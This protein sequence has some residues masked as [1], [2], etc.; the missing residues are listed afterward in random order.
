MSA[1]PDAISPDR[2]PIKTRSAWWVQAVTGGLI[3][4]GVSPNQVSLASIGFAAIGAALLVCEARGVVSA[5]ALIITAVCIQLRLLANVVDGLIAVEGGR[6]TKTGE[7]YNE[8]PDR[9][10]DVALLAAAGYASHYGELGIA[11]GWSASVLAVATA[12][13]R[14]L[15]ARRGQPQDFCGPQ[16]KQ[17]R[18]FLLTVACI[19]AFVEMLIGLTPRILFIFLIVI[20]LGT[21]LTCVR[22]TARLARR[23][24]TV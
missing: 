10:S 5:P 17:H 7:L 23:L 14:A 19:F 24:E 13:I 11:L 12:Y 6:Q 21:L 16:A 2:R 22:R 4:L 20:N 1:A 3:R 15:G 8:I 9:I 18:M